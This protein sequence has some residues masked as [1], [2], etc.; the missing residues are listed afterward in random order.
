[1]TD[2]ELSYAIQ[3]IRNGCVEFEVVRTLLDKLPEMNAAAKTLAAL[4]AAGVDNWE[5]YS[6]AQELME[7]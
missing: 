3:M 4:E 1:M 2:D 5:G 7:E 6:Y